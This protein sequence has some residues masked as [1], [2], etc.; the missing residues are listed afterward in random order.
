M[1]HLFSSLLM[2]LVFLPSCNQLSN[3]SSIVIDDQKLMTDLRIDPGMTQIT[4]DQAINVACLFAINQGIPETKSKNEISDVYTVTN[5]EGMP[6]FY[7]V[8]RAGNAG[9]T[10]VGAS[11]KYFPILG[12][13]DKGHFDEK[14]NDT[15]LSI[16]VN[17]QVVTVTAIEKGGVRDDSVDFNA[18]WRLYEKRSNN[19]FIK[20]KNEAE[21]F[22]LRQES[23]AAWEAQGYTCY[24]LMSCPNDLPSATYEAWCSWAQV[25]LGDGRREE[26]PG[27][28]R[29]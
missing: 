10:I 9:F 27:R 20:T 2:L 1:K 13:S 17:R 3:E 12:Y 16:W 4:A 25:W 29:C 24:S 6:V 11:R 19:S 8:N 14:Y 21:A 18:H 15:G 7:A 23:V 5:D 22:A 26:S 28:L